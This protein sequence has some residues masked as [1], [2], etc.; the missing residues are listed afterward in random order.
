MANAFLLA[1]LADAILSVADEIAHAAG[2][3][4]LTGVRNIVASCVVIASMAMALGLAL[5]PQLPKRILLLPVLF[6]LWCAIGAIPLSVAYSGRWLDF[7][8]SLTQLALAAMA[9]ALLRL[10]F[11]R[12]LLT[13]DALPHKNRL[14]LRIAGNV[15]VALLVVPL[16]LVI[17][18]STSVAVLIENG[19]KHYIRFGLAS[20]DSQ[21][22]TLVKDATTVR[23]V[24]MVHM[25][26]PQ[27]YR[28]LIASLPPE[29]LVLAEGVSDHHAL[30]SSGLNYHRAAQALGLQAQPSLGPPTQGPSNAR[31]VG[32]VQAKPRYAE[33]IN[34]D[35]DVSDF[36]PPT[37]R[38][39]SKVSALYASGSLRAVLLRFGELQKGFTPADYKTIVGDILTK[40][41]LHLMSAFDRESPGHKIIVI[42]WG[43]EHMPQVEALLL[44][45]GYRVQSTDVRRVAGYATIL[46]AIL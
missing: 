19:T 18:G 6:A 43:A 11:S 26:E 46:A 34:A 30:L 33:V 31:G 44:A 21:E 45:R 37:V 16:A 4:A 14:P 36:S 35:V 2:F 23:L 8:L 39:L 17:L 12:W 38:F 7:A 24:G 22:T 28:S 13:A 20:I 5:F 42:P 25:A 27:F 40:R 32:D 29:G 3:S 41:N 10:R 1:F 9:F 15:A